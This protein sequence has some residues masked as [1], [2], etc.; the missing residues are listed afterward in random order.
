M[1]KRATFS[2][3]SWPTRGATAREKGT[4]LHFLFAHQT[5]IEAHGVEMLVNKCSSAQNFPSRKVKT[6]YSRYIR[7]QVKYNSDYPQFCQ[8]LPVYA[9]CA[10]EESNKFRRFTSSMRMRV[11]MNSKQQSASLFGSDRSVLGDVTVNIF[12]RAA[13]GC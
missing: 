13:T 10:P 2:L 1:C 6:S 5:K 8:K 12:G 3:L 4:L 9:Y 11:M 7:L